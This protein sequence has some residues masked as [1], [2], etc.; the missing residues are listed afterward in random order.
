MI[1]DEFRE[2]NVASVTGNLEFIN[3]VS[4]KC[5]GEGKNRFATRALPIVT[6]RKSGVI[7]HRGE[8]KKVIADFGAYSLTCK[9][10]AH[11]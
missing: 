2:G 3:V 6:Q 4:A 9:N 8:M 11:G 1:G 5:Q 10:S 7:E